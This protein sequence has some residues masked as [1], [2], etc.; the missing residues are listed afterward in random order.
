MMSAWDETSIV[1][2]AKPGARTLTLQG[3]P[4]GILKVRAPS[5]AVL[6]VARRTLLSP[7]AQT[8][9]TCAPAT[10]ADCGST[11]FTLRSAAEAAAERN[12][13]R[14]TATN[15]RIPASFARERG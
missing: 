8:S 6:R 7:P 2:A 3:R 14:K 4:H 13:P 9:E 12:K 15:T 11:T 10:V 5:A 1:S